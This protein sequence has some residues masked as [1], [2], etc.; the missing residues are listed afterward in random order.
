MRV[1][2]AY[3]EA[4]GPPWWQPMPEAAQTAVSYCDIP[5]M[6]CPPPACAT[7]PSLPP[8]TLSL[9]ADFTSP[10]LTALSSDISPAHELSSP[11]LEFKLPPMP[12][13]LQQG[14]L[15]SSECVIVTFLIFVLTYSL[16]LRRL[17]RDDM[18]IICKACKLTSPLVYAAGP[19]CLQP[20][21]SRF[22][23]HMDPEIA[24]SGKA[25]GF[26][27]E[28]KFIQIRDQQPHP[29]VHP[30]S[31]RDELHNN[32]HAPDH[33]Q[34]G[35]WCEDCGRMVSRTS[36][37]T[38]VCPTA[39]CTTRRDVTPKFASW[40]WQLPYDSPLGEDFYM[41]ET[42]DYLDGEVEVAPGFSA[43]V[44]L[45]TFPFERQVLS[46]FARVKPPLKLDLVDQSLSFVATIR[47]TTE[48]ITFSPH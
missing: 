7:T 9:S 30:T 33:I 4:Q 48:P 31:L 44:D 15:I 36:W 12:R 32:S 26:D 46:R 41:D 47:S 10:V 40:N 18:V 34:H 3:C 45:F 14:T 20:G 23:S 22:W 17:D 16:S 27:L 13:K 25:I 19:V 42:V 24:K 2:F 43:R 1:A 39:G 6:S 5:S 38:Y 35:F 37:S 21:C 28:P 29:L 11:A 8:S